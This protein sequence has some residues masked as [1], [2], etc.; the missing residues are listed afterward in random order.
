MRPLLGDVLATASGHIGAAT[1]DLCLEADAAPSVV[2]ELVRLT[3]VMARC[4]DAFVQAD[5]GDSRHLLDAHGLA[6]LEARSAARHECRGAS[7]IG[8]STRLS[9]D[10]PQQPSPRLVASCRRPRSWPW[11]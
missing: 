11:A 6:M 7:H 9:C 10:D 4:A 5:R 2:R 8:T 3:A 1:G